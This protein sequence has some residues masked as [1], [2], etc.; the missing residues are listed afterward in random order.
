MLAPQVN[1]TMVRP[2]G[3]TRPEDLQRHAAVRHVRQFLL[4][5]PAVADGEIEDRAEDQQREEDRDRQQKVEQVI[6]FGRERGRLF[7]K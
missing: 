6:H 7:R 4:R 1:I 5:A 3:I 2:N